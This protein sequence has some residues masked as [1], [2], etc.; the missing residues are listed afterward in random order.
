MSQNQKTDFET[1]YEERFLK[2]LDYMRIFKNVNKYQDLG[3]QEDM[4]EGSDDDHN[5][6]PSMVS[7]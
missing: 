6:H 1:E 3:Q 2:N 7:G 4:Q 5:Y